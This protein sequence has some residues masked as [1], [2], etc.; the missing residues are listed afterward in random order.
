MQENSKPK[1]WKEIQDLVGT[2][3]QTHLNVLRDKY[4]RDLDILY[5]VIV[6]GLELIRIGI[7]NYQI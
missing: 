3:F 5:R 1:V 2:T 7:R 6:P 4:D